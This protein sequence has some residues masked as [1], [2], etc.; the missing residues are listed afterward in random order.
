M[1]LNRSSMMQFRQKLSKHNAPVIANHT[2]KLKKRESFSQLEQEILAKHLTQT[3]TINLSVN[4][5][6]T[7]QKPLPWWK[8]Y[9]VTECLYII[10]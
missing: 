9:Q 8:G 7:M 4:G 5:A 3:E 6:F 10:L 1:V 2:K